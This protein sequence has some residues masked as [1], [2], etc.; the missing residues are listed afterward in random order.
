MGFW[1]QGIAG[2]KAIG[3]EVTREQRQALNKGGQVLI[4]RGLLSPWACYGDDTGIL[5]QHGAQVYVPQLLDAEP[6][7]TP[8]QL[9]SGASLDERNEEEVL[10]AR[11]YLDEVHGADWREWPSYIGEI[12]DRGIGRFAECDWMTYARVWDGTPLVS[13]ADRKAAKKILAAARRRIASSVYEEFCELYEFEA[14]GEAGWQD[15]EAVMDDKVTV[16]DMAAALE[17]DPNYIEALVRNYNTLLLGNYLTRST[18][19]E[20]QEKLK[21][22]HFTPMEAYLE[23]GSDAATM[24]SRLVNRRENALAIINNSLSCDRARQFSRSEKEYS[25]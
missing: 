17:T 22:V 13:K 24:W 14:M 11:D 15:L 8:A 10:L 12:Q 21:V 4:I 1:D 18:K 6:V 7:A 16:E 9:E 25:F 5:D 2:L 23:P 20:D 3:V 19:R